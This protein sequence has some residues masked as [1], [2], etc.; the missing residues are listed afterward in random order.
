MAHAGFP[1]GLDTDPERVAQILADDCDDAGRHLILEIDGASVGEMHYRNRGDGNVEI[2]IK[3]CEA[4]WQGQGYGP[5]FLKVL[6]AKLFE[7][8][9]ENI[10]LDTNLTN[11]RAQQVYEKLGFQKLRVNH[12]SWTDQSGQRQ[13]SVDYALAK[14]QFTDCGSE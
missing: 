2:G 1:R 8:G 11:T 7:Q 12:N 13:S 9:Y 10:V 5:L 14:A 4:E 6:M 3:I